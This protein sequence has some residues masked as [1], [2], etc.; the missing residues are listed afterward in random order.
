MKLLKPLTYLFL[1]LPF[2][3]FWGC[4]KDNQTADPTG[5]PTAIDSTALSTTKWKHIA[6]WDYTRGLY[7]RDL[8]P[9]GRDT[10]NTEIL[11]EY[12]YIRLD[13]NFKVAYSYPFIQTT[14]GHFR[15]TRYS[16][17]YYTIP[18][19][20]TMGLPKENLIAEHFPDNNT[21]STILSTNLQFL[22]DSTPNLIYTLIDNDTDYAV[23]AI[24]NIDSAIIYT[25][26]LQFKNNKT[27][28]TR[29]DEIN[30][31]TANV[32]VQKTPW[33]I[34][35]QSNDK[36]FL[37]NDKGQLQ[38]TGIVSNFQTLIGTNPINEY[39]FFNR[40]TRKLQTTTDCTH[41][42]DKYSDVTVAKAMQSFDK[43]YL[44][45]IHKNDFETTTDIT[46]IDLQQNKRF[47]FKDKDNFEY[48]HFWVKGNI[49]YVFNDD[50]FY[51]RLLK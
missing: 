28:R 4:K 11:T 40:Q 19:T 20:N 24:E 37:I 14:R 25:V 31:A 34:M 3:L 29:I 47:E 38:H 6:N 49:L 21:V 15:F 23:Y 51:G 44:L 22:G 46:V 36:L 45:T 8:Q 50:G 42:Q 43:R 26:V 39:I 12:Q 10:S 33:E 35:L 48:N 17:F 7:F 41:W 27:T 18:L 2:T 9:W 1:T 16:S 32:L 30:W 13:K 5:N